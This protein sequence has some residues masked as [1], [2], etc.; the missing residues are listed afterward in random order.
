MAKVEVKEE[1]KQTLKDIKKASKI[2]KKELK[3][4][5]KVNED[6]KTYKVVKNHM[7]PSKIFASVIVWIIVATMLFGACATLI[8]YMMYY[9]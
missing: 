2:N 5:P 1:K 8:F 6:D 9:A 3:K 4:N 7:K